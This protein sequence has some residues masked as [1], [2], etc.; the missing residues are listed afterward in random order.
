MFDSLSIVG[1]RGWPVRFPDNTLAGFVAASTTADMVEF[2]VRRSADGKLVLAHDP[3]LA[4]MIVADT[5]WAS[6]VELDLGDGHRPALLDEVISALPETPIQMEV[7]NIPGQPGYE[8]DHRLGL[9]TAE[10]AR[11]VDVVTSF[12]PATLAAVRRV[13]SEVATGLAVDVLTTL[14]EAVKQ[15]L[16]VGHVALVPRHDMIVEPLDLPDSLA[17]YPWTVND[18]A[19]AV[20]L[21]E[22]GVSGIITDDPAGIRHHLEASP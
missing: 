16:D 9:E 19:R 11:P 18:P 14:D 21:A 15:C 8:P 12:N 22:L 5:P 10:R 7:K 6:L 20:E 13:Y 4:G 1:H 17:V 2:D 3:V